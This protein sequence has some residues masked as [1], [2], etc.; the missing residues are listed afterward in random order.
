MLQIIKL[1]LSALAGVIATGCTWQVVPPVEVEQ[2]AHIY[3]SEY[4]RHTR[5]ALPR[6][7]SE[8]AEPRQMIEYGFGDWD[9]YALEQRGPRSA[10]RALFRSRASALSRREVGY[11]PDPELFRRANFANYAV[12]F[13]VGQAEIDVLRTRLELQWDELGRKHATVRRSDEN[14]FL[15]RSDTPYHLLR[16]SNRQTAEWLRELG[17]DVKGVAVLSRF[18]VISRDQPGAGRPAES[19][20]VRE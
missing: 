3:V 11:Q 14:I 6:A 19:A 15:R 20:R 12:R 18:E 7:A 4:G 13:T 16:N 9:Y 17:C 10:L 8:V 1:G 5:L 2:P